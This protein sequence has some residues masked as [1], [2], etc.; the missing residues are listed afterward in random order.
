MSDDL[1]TF[2]NGLQRFRSGA[3]AIAALPLVLGVALL[4]SDERMQA[5]QMIILSLIILFLVLWATHCAEDTIEKLQAGRQ[6]R[7]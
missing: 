2:R 3:I 6:N 7:D 4:L 1:G 5:A